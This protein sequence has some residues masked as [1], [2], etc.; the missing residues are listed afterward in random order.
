MPLRVHLTVLNIDFDVLINN[1][2][3]RSLGANDQWSQSDMF[4]LSQDY[5]CCN[6]LYIYSYLKIV[7]V[8]WKIRTS[9]NL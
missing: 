9:T 1:S 5:I 7:L 2:H 6:R 4:N 8:I 3:F